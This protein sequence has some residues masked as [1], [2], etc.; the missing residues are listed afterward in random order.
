MVA[1]IQ[2]TS[3]FPVKLCLNITRESKKLNVFRHVD[4]ISV[5]VRQIVSVASC[6]DR[7]LVHG[8]SDVVL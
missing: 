7:R 6:T 2:L 8:T 4:T 3:P 1:S 5:T